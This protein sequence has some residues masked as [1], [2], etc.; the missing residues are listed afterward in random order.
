MKQS[1][2]AFL[3]HKCSNILQLTPAGIFKISNAKKI[4]NQFEYVYK[5]F[6]KYIKSFKI[7]I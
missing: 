4:V 7:W 2:Y 3:Y 5:I 6:T 1:T